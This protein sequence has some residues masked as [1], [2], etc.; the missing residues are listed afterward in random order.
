MDTRRR[1]LIRADVLRLIIIN[2]YYRIST[3]PVLGKYDYK[4]RL[5]SQFR[6]T[7]QQIVY[8]SVDT[9]IFVVKNVNDKIR[10]LRH[11][12]PIRANR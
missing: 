11:I 4:K 2:G 12:T 6:Y 8:G 10:S 1:T 7:E 5:K 3:D 9:I